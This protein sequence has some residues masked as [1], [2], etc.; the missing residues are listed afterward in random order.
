MMPREAGGTITTPDYHFITFPDTTVPDFR[1][2]PFVIKIFTDIAASVLTR[3]RLKRK[4][5]DGAK[6]EPRRTLSQSF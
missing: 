4:M 5:A 3:C 6:T 2:I 1:I